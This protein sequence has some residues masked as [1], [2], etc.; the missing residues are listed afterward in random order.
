MAAN[1]ELSKCE[2]K[3]RWRLT[4]ATDPV[5]RKKIRLTLARH[6]PLEWYQYEPGTDEHA[7]GTFEHYIDALMYDKYLPGNMM[8]DWEGPLGV[9]WLN[10]QPTNKTLEKYKKIALN[11]KTDGHGSWEPQRL[12][13]FLNGRQ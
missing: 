12:K 2:R 4:E 6:R 5:E 11:R 7:R 9:D 1:R 8:Y 10:L 13:D 3:L